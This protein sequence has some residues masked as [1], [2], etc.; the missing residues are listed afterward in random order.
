MRALLLILDSVGCGSAPDAA[1]YGDEGSDT[2]GHI[3]ERTP[4]FALPNLEQLGVARILNREN[5][6]VPQGSWGR[7]RERSAGKDT[8]TGHWE[9][10]GAVLEKPFTVFEEFPAELVCAI[11][12]ETG[13][14]FIGNF[15]RSGTVVLEEL[16]A[17][18]Y[19]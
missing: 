9:I 2:L 7:M 11:E 3:Y 16:G 5:A 18:N 4:G 15:P 10:A 19:R 1:A 8:T 14:E 13:V 12:H 6:P 17:E